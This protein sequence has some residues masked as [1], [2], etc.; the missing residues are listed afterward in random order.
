MKAHRQLLE[1]A[2]AFLRPVYP[3]LTPEKLASALA[4][5]ERQAKPAAGPL[6]ALSTKATTEAFGVCTRTLFQWRK[7]GLIHPKRIGRRKLFYD[8]REVES[9]I[10]ASG[11]EG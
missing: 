2:V 7:A 3:D 1:G 5:I 11:R 9:L 10:A 4:G 6:R 8:P